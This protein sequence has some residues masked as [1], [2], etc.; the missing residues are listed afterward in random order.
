MPPKVVWLNVG[1]ARNA[2][3]AKLLQSRAS[4][5]EQFIEHDDYTF[6]AIGIENAAS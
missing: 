3:L 6:L 2:A 4:E 1:S 5:I